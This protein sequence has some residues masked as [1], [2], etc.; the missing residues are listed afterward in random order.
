ML[1]VPPPIVASAIVLTARLVP[2]VNQ[3]VE[4]EMLLFCGWRRDLGSMIME[5]D[6]Q[7]PPGS[8]VT[9]MSPMPVDERLQALR[10]SKLQ[11]CGCVCV[12]MCVC[13]CGCVSTCG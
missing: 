4:P 12:C 2:G 8:S 13:G 10:E 5:L 6:V 7:C 9:L 1:L 11:V 3:E